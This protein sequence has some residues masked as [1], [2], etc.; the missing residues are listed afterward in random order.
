MPEGAVSLAP[1][2]RGTAPSVVSYVEGPDRWV[3]TVI[4][5]AITGGHAVAWADFD[6]DGDDELVAGW[7]DGAYGLARYRIGGDGSLRS[8]QLIDRGVA[9][10]DLVVADINSDGRPD[11]VACGRATGNI[12][13]FINDGAGQ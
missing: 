9:V 10:E 12:R 2:S 11:I 13:L 8:R 4:D 1:S 5:D 3:R 6:G 7:R